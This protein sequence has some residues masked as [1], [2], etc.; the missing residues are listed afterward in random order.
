MN[1]NSV[2]RNRFSSPVQN[3]KTGVENNKMKL[4]IVKVIQDMFI[5]SETSDFASSFYTI[6][7]F[8]ASVNN[9]DTYQGV[10]SL[11]DAKDK[12]NNWLKIH[13]LMNGMNVIDAVEGESN[14]SFLSSFISVCDPVITTIDIRF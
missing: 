8:E 7:P 1:I 14:E 4:K 5:P 12:A 2:S 10:K 6:Y 3:M 11:S 9:V 13:E